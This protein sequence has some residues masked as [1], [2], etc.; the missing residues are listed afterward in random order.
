MQK[1]RTYGGGPDANL[2]L[3]QLLGRRQSK[4]TRDAGRV[5]ELAALNRELL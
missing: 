3:S 2:E 1:R 5:N 4:T